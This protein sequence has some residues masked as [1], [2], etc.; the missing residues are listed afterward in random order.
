MTAPQSKLP[1]IRKNYFGPH[2]QILEI[3]GVFVKKKDNIFEENVSKIYTIIKLCLFEIGFCTLEFASLLSSWGNIDEVT[4][5]LSFLITHFVGVIKMLLMIRRR[6]NIWK[7]CQK[8]ESDVFKPN[9]ERGGS[10]EFHKIHSAIKVIDMQAIFFHAVVV[11]I[12]T[13]RALSTYSEIFTEG[14]DK[15]ANFTSGSLKTKLPFT[16]WFPLTLHNKTSY[17]LAFWY[18]IISASFY[19]LVIGSID[20]LI[21][22]MMIHIKTQIIILKNNVSNFVTK[23]EELYGEGY[24]DE[25]EMKEINRA[26]LHLKGIEVIPKLPKAVQ[27]KTKEVVKNCIHHHQQI[28]DISDKI[29][30]EFNLLMLAQFLGSVI[31]FCVVLFQLSLVNLTKKTQKSF[32]I[33]NFLLF[34][35][36]SILFVSIV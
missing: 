7:Y 27:L 17:L 1:K 18:E 29:E 35:T 6:N 8:L 2:L 4:F 33:R 16:N 21:T 13:N 20:T 34:S 36:A 22:G 24:Y 26:A 11:S 15:V 14:Y 30:E 32:I 23:A 12:V 19:G 25:K 10:V 3:M 28:I 31:M 5:S 9:Y